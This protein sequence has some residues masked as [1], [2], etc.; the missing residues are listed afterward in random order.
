MAFFGKARRK[1]VKN[2]WLAALRHFKQGF[3][4]VKLL[5]AKSLEAARAL[6]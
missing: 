6:T 4:H 5:E 3:K 1:R 2:S